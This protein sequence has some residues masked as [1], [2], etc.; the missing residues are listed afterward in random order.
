MLNGSIRAAHAGRICAVVGIW[1]VLVEVNI[2]ARFYTAFTTL[3]QIHPEDWYSV[4]SHYDRQACYGVSRAIGASRGR[5]AG[6]DLRVFEPG[7]SGEAA[8][9][10]RT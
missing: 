5:S 4:T 7:A 6:D 8:I 2:R 9:A 1:G 3:T 10:L